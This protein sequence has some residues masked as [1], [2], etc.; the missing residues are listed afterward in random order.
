MRAVSKADLS[1]RRYKHLGVTRGHAMTIHAVG[2]VYGF[3]VS[4][5]ILILLLLLFVDRQ[6][7]IGYQYRPVNS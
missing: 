5:V 4:D 2:L 7:T 3:V 6:V 1:K